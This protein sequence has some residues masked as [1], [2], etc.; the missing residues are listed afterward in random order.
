[1]P[2]HFEYANFTVSDNDLNNPTERGRPVPRDR[3]AMQRGKGLIPSDDS[4]AICPPVPLPLLNTNRQAG[5]VCE[6]AGPSTERAQRDSD[7]LSDGDDDCV[8]GWLGMM[9]T[10]NKLVALK[11]VQRQEQEFVVAVRPVQRQEQ[12]FACKLDD[13]LD[14]VWQ[15]IGLDDSLKH[16]RCNHSG[17]PSRPLYRVDRLPAADRRRGRRTAVTAQNYLGV[18]HTERAS[19]TNIASETSIDCLING[20]RASKRRTG[21]SNPVKSSLEFLETSD[22]QLRS[23][24]T[25][26]EPS[27]E[28]CGDAEECFTNWLAE[29]YL[30]DC[31]SDLEFVE[32]R[33]SRLGSVTTKLEPS[34]ECQSDAEECF[35]DWLAEEYL[36]S[37][38]CDK[39]RNICDTIDPMDPYISRNRSHT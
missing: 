11:P 5:D 35:T 34:I 30:S 20:H 10:S 32:T 28:C 13:E 3:P 18:E 17:L 14:P 22:S 21:G 26:L 39:Q 8:D 2:F 1:M 31:V 4:L 16:D 7:Y 33:D 38:R 12:E 23:V 37:P 15:Q 36:R 27:I 29:E 24:T 6:T 19:E 9:T 25:K